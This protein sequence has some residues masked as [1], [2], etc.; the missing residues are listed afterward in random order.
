M[1]IFTH[2]FILITRIEYIYQ[3]EECKN[4][5]QW[6][7]NTGNQTVQPWDPR[8]DCTDKNSCF[9][10]GAVSGSIGMGVGGQAEHGGRAELRRWTSELG[11]SRELEFVERSTGKRRDKQRKRSEICKAGPPIFG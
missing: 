5:K 1:Y 7:S 2:K 11:R 4:V 8:G 6:L 3:Q 9:L 10:G